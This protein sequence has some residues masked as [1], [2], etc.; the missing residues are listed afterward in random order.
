MDVRGATPTKLGVL[1]KGAAQVEEAVSPWIFKLRN[2][3]TGEV[4]EAHVSRI[5]FYADDFMVSEE[6][7][8]HVVHHDQGNVV[9]E[10]QQCRFN[11]DAKTYEILVNGA[12]S[13]KCKSPG[14]LR[15]TYGKMCLAW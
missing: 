3:A 14:S 7:L 15:K 6:V 1:W 13:A 12:V 4:R 9:E 2:I 11:Q 5:R 10:L 8:A